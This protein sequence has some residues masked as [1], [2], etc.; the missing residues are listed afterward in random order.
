MNNKIVGERD[1]SMEELQ[2]IYPSK[3]F[4]EFCKKAVNYYENGKQA[5]QGIAL[6]WIGFKLHPQ[7]H[8]YIWYF[9]L[10]NDNYP[11]IFPLTKSGEPVPIC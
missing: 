6:V 2:Y 11:P 4:Y 10:E 9:G 5:V 1:T 8:P 3:L 7:Y